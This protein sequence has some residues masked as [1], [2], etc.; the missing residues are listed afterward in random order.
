MSHDVAA[1]AGTS[2]Y[3][4]IRL[5]GA[6]GMGAVY[7]VEDRT[8]GGRVALK[9]M[10]AD[11]AGR[12]L[13]F[14]N[15]FRVMAELHHPNLVR[16]FDLGQHEGQW[17]FTMELVHGDDL[18]AVL[19]DEDAG[20]TATTATIAAVPEAVR[21]A[22]ET[23]TH[24]D[25]EA[26]RPAC[27][28]DALVPVVAQIL[29]ALAYLHG[30]GIVHRDLKPSNI[31][32]D[33]DGV[34]RVLDFGLASRL[35]R[36][37]AIS[38]DGAV[39]G[40]LA[41]LSPEQYR[42][43]PASPASD[44]YALGCMLFQ[45]LTG[46][47][48]FRG[49]PMQALAQRNERPPPR[50]DER[51]GGVP[52]A[53]VSIVH[54]LMARDPEARPT[55]AEVR[56]ALGLAGEAQP[57]REDTA[58]I[59]VGRQ[60]ELSILAGCLERATGGEPQLA[61]V[62]GPSGIGKSALGG[63]VA[64][65]AAQL[66][67]LCL[68]GRCYE[69]ERVPFVA[70]D[71]VMDELTLALRRWPR[72]RLAPLRPS[73]AALSRIFPGL[74]MLDGDTVLADHD[75]ADP[76]ELRRLAIDG[77]RDLLARVQAETPLCFV[78]DDLQWA[79]EESIALLADLLAGGAGRILIAGL[80]RDDG[81]GAGHPLD[82][83]LRDAGDAAHTTRI[84]LSALGS[85]DAALLVQ[86][87]SGGHL[88]PETSR[89][90]VSQAAGNP[91]LVRR[92]AE[93]LATLGP[94]ERSQG[95]GAIGSADE[96]LR[97]MIAGLSPRAEEVLAVVAAAGS[98]VAAP[99]LRAASDLPAAE[100]DLAVAELMAARFLKAVPA[101]DGEAEALPRLDLYHDR[102]REVA[103]AALPEDRRRAL[104]LR[105]AL[106]LEALPAGRG[107]DAEVL[108]HHFGAA[109]DRAR[110]RS[111]AVAAADQA[112]GKLAF[113]RAARLL[114]VVLDEPDPGE[115]ALATAARWER[116]G[117]LYEYGGHHLDA[118]RAYQ[119]ALRRWDDAPPDHRDRRAARLRLR[120][121]A[122]VNLMATPHSAEGRAV[123]ESGLALL[124]LPLARP[125]PQRIAIIA[126]LR[127]QNAIAERLGSL[128]LPRRDAPLADE[129]RFLD[130][131]VRAFTPLWPW[132]AAEAAQRA[133]LLGRRIGDR[134]VL[135]RALASA[136]SVP[137][138]VGRPSPEEIDRAHRRLDDAEELA[139]AHDIPL[140]REI[141]Q[142]NRALIWLVTSPERARRTA[143]AALA[144][145]TRRGMADSYDGVVARV[146]HLCVLVW[147]GDDEDALAAA[148]REIEHP[149]ENF[150]NT[151]FALAERVVLLARRGRVDEARAW[152]A[153]A[154]AH[155][156]GAPPSRIV[157]AVGRARCALL[158]AEGRCAEALAEAD[159]QEATARETGAWIVGVD[160][161]MWHAIMLE[162]A[163]GQL[164][165]GA[166]SARER[167]RAHAA[168]RWLTD[169]GVL[170]FGCLGVRALGLL[171]RA[172]G[173]HRRAAGT[174]RRALWLSSANTSPYH[175]WLCLEAAREAGILTLD[176]EAEA[177]EL[178][179][180]GHFARPSGSA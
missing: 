172:E 90:L 42:G 170:D 21:S 152:L 25:T 7:E 14:K 34:V 23:D 35:D 91:F 43:E 50:V 49:P 78:L 149:Q 113:A 59:F 82:R 159:R 105:L 151:A 122:G 168:A 55:I 138:I 174:L 87:V 98:D 60:R 109:G 171:D 165:K 58:E 141:V 57:A 52:P 83:L 180:A 128:P 20:P 111:Y 81:V 119:E 116:A 51:V 156:A 117:D 99:L 71:R 177:A 17:F 29:D 102:I 93:H 175:R 68:R 53:L 8:T 26:R 80:F 12:L 92:L 164:Q 19:L 69:R 76:R 126:A 96:L 61:L 110:A 64:R 16:L 72:A 62:S 5:L 162:A 85:S 103:Y 11:D 77:F 48:P 32:V 104:H 95:L 118:A 15:E 135:L 36:E 158:V 148:E 123:F 67:F 176:Q 74:A 73:I 169:R 2:R 125:I 88:E 39:V 129:V 40:T 63:M 75:G 30:R 121:L 79:D 31:L 161:S 33:V 127:A 107:R 178:A 150:V 120:G 84:S 37:A 134:M 144:G 114:R 3:R 44:L 46:E 166:L 86:A 112:A 47:L 145:F 154:G 160:R 130:H 124:G 115:P 153:R 140:G 27:D 38:Q 139:R 9:V 163:L 100:L 133:E 65:R 179:A 167:R 6:G 97:K 155:L 41:Y 28:P 24:T 22:V 131:M 106:A 89:A 66:G 173:H 94:E 143:E 1:F 157:L 18:L 45:L 4:P 132:P 108:V 13:R 142:M 101:A 147:K 146:F 137:V 54:R 136:A 56:A 10:L 70:F